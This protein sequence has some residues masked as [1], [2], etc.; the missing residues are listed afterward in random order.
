MLI[1][2]RHKIN[3]IQMNTRTFDFNKYTVTASLG[4]R[5]IY[6]KMIDQVNYVTYE[7]TVD[8]KELRIQF[9]LDDIYQLIC[10]SFDTVNGYNVT[11]SISNGFMKLTFQLLVAGF[12]KVNFDAMLKEKVL[13]NDGQLTLNMN[14]M[15]QHLRQL[16]QKL[17]VLE[18]QVRE[19][20]E[21]L[22]N[23]VIKITKFNFNTYRENH[24]IRIGEEV[25]SL[26]NSE[27][28]MDLTKLAYLYRLRKLTVNHTHDVMIKNKTVEEMEFTG[29]LT[30]LDI[31]HVP[32]LKQLTVRGATSLTNVV[33]SLSA[34][35]HKI[36]SLTFQ[37]CTGINVVELQT[38]CQTNKIE[39]NIS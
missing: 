35:K 33:A 3:T 31:S 13:S 2:I 29:N 27:N 12:L 37:G 6:L 23:A 18:E 15:E 24:F 10:H 34:K 19:K 11:I 30:K 39:L 5:G 36:Q 20:N 9:A 16:E 1:V 21:L 26:E 17:G 4:E 32:N 7:G 25:L 14:R 22:S 28:Y 38:Y 8:A